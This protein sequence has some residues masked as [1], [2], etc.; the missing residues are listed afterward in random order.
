MKIYPP[1][2]LPEPLKKYL[3]GL[4]AKVVPVGSRTKGIIFF[5]AADVSTKSSN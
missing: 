1:T 5:V 4:K 3:K 2:E